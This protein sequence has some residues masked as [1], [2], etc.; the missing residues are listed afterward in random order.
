MRRCDDNATNFPFIGDVA[1]YDENGQFYFVER[2]K[3]IIKCM[4][5]HVRPREM[6]ELILN[7]FEGIN[8][9]A[10]TGIPDEERGEVA[11]AFVVLKSSH[12]EPQNITEAM[13]QKYVAGISLLFLLYLSGN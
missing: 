2:N 13:I 5:N 8:E 11:L 6:E 10:V 4:D 12:G 7:H 1:Y 9:V 3:L